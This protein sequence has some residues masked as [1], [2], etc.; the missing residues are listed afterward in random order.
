VSKSG[1]IKVSRAL[2]TEGEDPA[3]QPGY[4]PCATLTEISV[5]GQLRNRR[6]DRL[7]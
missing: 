3:T 5:A 6:T 4:Q 7:Q 2:F 1:E